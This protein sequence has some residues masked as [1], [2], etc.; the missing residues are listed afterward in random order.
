MGAGL[1][2]KVVEEVG[3]KGVPSGAFPA[4]SPAGITGIG[5][6]TERKQF[7]IRQHQYHQQLD[8]DPA[9]QH[10]VK[11][12]WEARKSTNMDI[13]R[14]N[15]NGTYNFAT[16]GTGL[17]GN[18]ATG[19]RLREL[20]RGRRQCLQP[21]RDRTARPLQ[22]VPGRLRSGRL[23]NHPQLHAQHRPAVGNRYADHGQEQPDE[24]LRSASP[25]TRFPARRA[26]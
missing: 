12:G 8:V 9:N 25:S 23:E 16:T 2:S 22:L 18:T 1:G 13:N 11:F 4:I 15:I 19:T 24:Q 14:P 21:A 5:S 6:P 20:P 26:W 3:L 17:P 10:Q 7:P